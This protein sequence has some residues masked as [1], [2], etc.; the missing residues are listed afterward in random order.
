M[1]FAD[2]LSGAAVC[3]RR[4]FSLL[5]FATVL[6]AIA[7]SASAQ[8]IMMKDGRVIAT[9]GMRRTGDTII[10]TVEVT[11]PGGGDK[12]ATTQTGEVGY[13]LAQIARL[14]FP[15]PVQLRTVPDLIVAGRLPEALA[16]IEPVVRY[17]ESFRDAP[18]S[19]WDEAALIK[20]QIL[21]AMG[22]VKDADP[23]T[24]S[25]SRLATDPE[26]ARAA[27]VLAGAGLTRRGEHAKAIEIFD[28]LMKD[29][30]KPSTLATAAL[31]KGLSHLALK[32][33]E[34]ALLS[35]LQIPVFF[36]NQKLLLPQAMLGSAKAYYALEDYERAKSTLNELLT[37]F[38]S[39]PQAAEAKVELEKVAK[40]EKALA[41]PK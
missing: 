4:R 35:F 3:K 21:V 28:Q 38:G 40:R 25:L 15:E 31:N 19:W 13:P 18:G 12:P 24:D 17:Y 7:C 20:V 36:P 22:N 33:Y 2:R 34:P 14:D 27:K 29:A 5:G 10:A 9:K 16:Q 26:T 6:I 8:N 41:P 37:D 30:I 39:S 23:L 11:I 1:R 32:Q